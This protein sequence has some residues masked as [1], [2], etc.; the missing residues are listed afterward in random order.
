MSDNDNDL[1]STSIS[2]TTV[3]L[4]SR[5]PD[6]RRQ[7]SH[8]ISAFRFQLLETAIA[9]LELGEADTLLIEVFEDY[10]VQS[11]SG[12]TQLTQVKHSVAD[13]RLTL[14]SK[15]AQDALQNY[16]ATSR[17]GLAPGVSLLVHTNM[18]IGQERGGRLPDGAA[19]IQYWQEVREGAD[20]GPLKT[21]LLS[22]LPEG[23]L[24][25]WLAS[26]PDDDAIKTRLVDRVTW[27]TAQAAGSSQNALLTELIAGRLAALEL[28]VGLAPTCAASI[29]DRVGIVASDT[30]ASLRKLR[31]EDLHTFLSEASRSGQPG[32][33]VRW[34]MSSWTVP[35]EEIDLPAYIAPREQLVGELANT[36]TDTHALWLHGASGT[37]KSTLAQ[38]VAAMDSRRW[39]VAEFR[40]QDQ[41]TETLLRLDRAYTDVALGSEIGGVILD[42][43]DV[44]V[45][46]QHP[47]RFARF[48]SWMKA[49]DGAVVFTCARTVSPNALQSLGLEASAVSNSSYLTVEDVTG[50]IKNTDAPTDIADAWGLFIHTATSGG[51]PQLVAA[52]IVSLEHRGWPK[53]ALTEDLSGQVSEAVEL[54]RTEA[55]RRL[56]NDATD[57]G[58]ALLKRLGC[59]LF[60]FDRA[61]AIA[62]AT[63]APE[64]KEP[65]ASLDLLTGPWIE[66]VPSA[67]GF[68]RLSPLLTGLHED[69]GETTIK[70]V[71]VGMLVST[72]Q[73]GP[74]PYEALDS[75]F[76]TAYT[77]KQGWFFVKFFESSLSFDEDKS[78]AIAAKLAPIVYLTTEEPLFPEEPGTSHLLRLMQVDIAAQNGEKTLFQPIA[79]AAMREA[80]LQDSKEPQDALTLMALF[81]ILFSHGTTLD[82]G[83]RLT[84]ISLFEALA[85][86]E[87]DLMARSQSGAVKAMKAEFGEVADVGGFMLIIGAQSVESPAELKALFVALDALEPVLRTRRLAQLKAFFKGYGLHVQS[88]WVRVWS[89]GTLEAADAINEFS[90]MA[91]LAA[92]WGDDDLVAECIVAQSVIWDEFQ[93]DRVAALSVID[94]ALRAMPAHAELLRQKAKVYGHDGQYE[95]AR[96]ILEIIRPAI[97]ERSDIERMYA[98]KEQAVATAASGDHETTRNLFCEAAAAAEGVSGEVDSIHAHSL[99]LRAEAA[100]CAWHAGD[101]ETALRELAP[102]VDSLAGIDPKTDQ[103]S[104]MLHAKIRWLVGWLFETS[105]TPASEPPTLKPGAIAALDGNYP[106]DDLK[107]GARQ[108]DIKLLLAAVALRYDIHD[109]FETLDWPSTTPGFHIFLK[110]GEFDLAVESGEPKNA[111]LAAL[112]LTAAFV[113][114]RRIGA[115]DK[116]EAANL[117]IENAGG[118][119]AADLSDEMAGAIIS[120]AI[121]LAVFMTAGNRVNAHSYC[122]ELLSEVEKRLGDK[123]PQINRLFDLC[124]GASDPVVGDHAELVLTDALRTETDVLYPSETINQQLA[125]LQ[126]AVLCG[127][128]PR[129]V[130]RLFIKISDQWSFVLERQRFLLTNPARH[131]PQLELA[132]EALQQQKPG[133][134][135]QLLETAGLALNSEIPPVWLQVAEKLGGR[136]NGKA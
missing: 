113:I 85:G 4:Q 42:D 14:A 112:N 99:A 123:S 81:K 36:L 26:S 15:D 6:P 66:P 87:P 45:L 55:R 130:Q 80:R 88:A 122:T 74:I 1:G 77:A 60:K 5:D 39:L 72:I 106:E 76:W 110:A 12:D 79:I 102:I 136:A 126:C 124:S 116:N 69:L 92:S 13:R 120:H 57:E 95:K 132:I 129:I 121:A 59:I 32:H 41:A 33:E 54:T 30:D 51:H 104:R 68:M 131:A 52:K 134:L 65:A 35:A 44:D 114:S 25:T 50:L 96:L 108:E 93:D 105:G 31:V 10:D 71:R 29:I 115:G 24:R 40:G 107:V 128:G 46:A 16:W 17:A 23:K 27:K 78:E 18:Q 70:D 91:S 94:A 7:A 56:L 73:R 53:D 111:A 64:I 127:C 48:I 11:G 86:R 47:R 90:E 118:L 49:R 37:G 63:I 67:P 125:L 117:P 100:I 20:A 58:R 34:S 83:L 84:W 97:D 89:A 119:S 62:S 82:W 28:P 38:Q 103:A 101:H 22:V 61:T 109:V 9:W 3:S 43:V 98:I 8:I 135:V 19:G 75:L 133:S 21:T 2:E